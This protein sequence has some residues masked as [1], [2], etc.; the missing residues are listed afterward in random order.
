MFKPKVWGAPVIGWLAAQ[1]WL[2]SRDWARRC[3][4]C[5]GW[6]W[7]NSLLWPD[8]VPPQSDTQV[9]TV[10]LSH[11]SSWRGR[12]RPLRSLISKPPPPLPTPS[13]DLVWPCSQRAVS[14]CSYSATEIMSPFIAGFGIA[15]WLS[16]WQ[17]MKAEFVR[18]EL[19]KII[20]EIQSYFYKDNSPGHSY[21]PCTE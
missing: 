15:P 1:L 16:Q 14:E 3:Q 10:W 11:R 6:T 7:D 18:D 13:V 21:C 9:H 12:R 4:F 2:V 19:R 5:L 20:T 8:S 17:T